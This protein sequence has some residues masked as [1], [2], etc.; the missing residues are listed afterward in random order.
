[1]KFLYESDKQIFEWEMQ[2]DKESGGNQD[3]FIRRRKGVISQLKDYHKSQQGKS[4]WRANRWQHLRGIK[5]FAK[6]TEGKRF[7]RALGNFLAN[8]YMRD[9]PSSQFQRENYDFLL[10]LSS[11]QTHALL[12]NDYYFPS[13][14]EAAD[15][16]FFS[17]YVIVETAKIIQELN[18]ETFQFEQYEEL[19]LRLVETSEL[20][21]SFADK[22][23]KSISDVENLWDQAKEI[24]KN[25]Y[26]KKEEDDG[27]YALTVGVLKNSLGKK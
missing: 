14:V 25:E 9:K 4:S 18:E 21:K 15:Y 19:L 1:M 12:E 6:S 23:G 11:L 7:H 3:K 2:N 5:R 13:I 10:S 16:E 24:V 20:I 26:D 8:R 27:F 17:E 22:S